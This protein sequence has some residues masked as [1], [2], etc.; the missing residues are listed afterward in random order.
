MKTINDIE[1]QTESR[2][3][4]DLAKVYFGVKLEEDSDLGLIEFQ[5]N[6]H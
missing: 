6:P 1:L 4:L 5:K 2:Y 3:N